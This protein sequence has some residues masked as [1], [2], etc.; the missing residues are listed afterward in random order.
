MTPSSHR[1]SKLKQWFSLSRII[2]LL[3]VSTAG[4]VGVLSL[5][6]Y[7]P[8]S[9]PESVIIVLL[10]LLAVDSLIERTGILERIDNKLNA[11]EAKPVLLLGP[12]YSDYV[13]ATKQ[14]SEIWL[15]AVSAKEVVGQ[16]CNFFLEMLKKGCNIRII[17]LNPNCPAIKTWDLLNNI[18]FTETD[19]SSVLELL[20]QL[21][22]AHGAKGKC[23]V[24]LCEFFTPFS[25]YAL[26]PN[27][28]NGKI[29]VSYYGIAKPPRERLHIEFDAT[30]DFQ[31]LAYY[32]QQFEDVWDKSHA[33]S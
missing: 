9:A 7:L 1:S 16:Y 21:T 19:I 30:A 11:I 25:L 22:S 18:K 24:R 6:G 23:E 26:N 2:P 12:D 14:A 20:K 13:E 10:A 15:L 5:F 28:T 29:I 8:L 17:L 32:R 31:W 33:W 3:T 27:K 4:I